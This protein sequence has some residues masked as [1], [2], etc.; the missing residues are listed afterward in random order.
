MHLISYELYSNIYFYSL[1]EMTSFLQI[2]M[3]LSS[4]CLKEDISKHFNT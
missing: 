4:H 3:L 1:C 2:G